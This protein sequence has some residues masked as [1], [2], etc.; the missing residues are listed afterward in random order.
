MA[1]D[2]LCLMRESRGMP[3][4]Q[5]DFDAVRADSNY[6]TGIEQSFLAKPF[7]VDAGSIATAKVERSSGQTH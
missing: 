2:G 7:A 1:F 5:D 4:G 3:F 6:V